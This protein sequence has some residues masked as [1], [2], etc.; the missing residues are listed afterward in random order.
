MHKQH[1]VIN[2]TAALYAFAMN[3][4]TFLCCFFEKICISFFSKMAP[5]NLAKLGLQLLVT[6]LIIVAILYSIDPA[7]H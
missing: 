2:W 7:T 5:N 6:M 4:I 3:C 1:V